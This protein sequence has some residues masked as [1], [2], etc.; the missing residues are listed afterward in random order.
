M[1]ICAHV[2]S[3][4]IATGRTCMRESIHSLFVFGEW[5]GK[6]GDDGADFGLGRATFMDG[7]FDPFISDNKR[8]AQLGGARQLPRLPTP[9]LHWDLWDGR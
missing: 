3:L 5:M 9:A 1:M 8:K 4:L 7:R 6:A 2:Y